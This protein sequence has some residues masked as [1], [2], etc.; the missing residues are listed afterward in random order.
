MATLRTLAIISVAACAGLAFTTL[1]GRSQSVGA[2]LKLTPLAYSSQTLHRSTRSTKSRRTTQRR[3]APRAVAHNQAERNI[4][5]VP[6]GVTLTS[7]LPWWRASDLQAI[8]YRDRADESPVLSA[9]DAWFA[10]LGVEKVTPVENDYALASP[11]EFNEIDLAAN[12][13]T[14]ADASE[15]NAIDLAADDGPQ[16]QPKSWLNIL[17][18][19]L[20]GALAV[21]STARFL[22]V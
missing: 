18:A 20:G 4:I 22:F 8:R 15:V 9:A 6:D 17:L 10:A 11:D 21:A 16:D 2:P 1:P 13:M 3:V 5:Q 14:V 7:L 19:S 12:G